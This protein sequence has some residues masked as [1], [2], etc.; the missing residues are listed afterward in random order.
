MRADCIRDS[1]K[2]QTHTFNNGQMVQA[3]RTLYNNHFHDPKHQTRTNILLNDLK[4]RDSWLVLSWSDFCFTLLSVVH[5]LFLL[6]VIF[7]FGFCF[8]LNCT[9][10]R[11]ISSYYQWITLW[12]GENEPA[13]GIEHIMFVYKYRKK[14][15]C[16]AWVFI[17]VLSEF[18]LH[19]LHEDWCFCLCL[20]RWKILITPIAYLDAWHFIF[21][22]HKK[23]TTTLTTNNGVKAQQKSPN[24]FSRFFPSFVVPMQS[25]NSLVLPSY[26][27]VL[28]YLS[29]DLVCGKKKCSACG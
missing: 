18:N 16:N 6:C 3:K 1:L 13:N 11:Q 17:G 9:Q 23:K 10:P 29:V 5:S 25:H 2:R 19:R 12:M 8:H 4:Q 27:L 21:K 20:S 14:E 7:V 26:W 15:H 22:E 28:T 24:E